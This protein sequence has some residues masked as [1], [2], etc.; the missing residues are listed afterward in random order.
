[1]ART[2]YVQSSVWS[3]LLRSLPEGVLSSYLRACVGRLPCAR[4]SVYLPT[5][6]TGVCSCKRTPAVFCREECGR[7]IRRFPWEGDAAASAG[8]GCLSGD[9]VAVFHVVRL[10]ALHSTSY[11]LGPLC[12]L[13]RSAVYATAYGGSLALRHF[14]RSPDHT[15]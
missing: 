10:I 2:Y 11:I 15:V 12:T 4:P 9:L 6:S 7:D 13:L 5:V 8:A 14:A 3:L 1:M